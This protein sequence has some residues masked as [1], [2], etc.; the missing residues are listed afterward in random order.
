MRNRTFIVMT[1]EMLA[2]SAISDCDELLKTNPAVPVG[3]RAEQARSAYPGKPFPTNSSTMKALVL[4][5][6]HHRANA[7]LKAATMLRLVCRAGSPLLSEL[8]TLFDFGYYNYAV[9][10]STEN[11][12][13]PFPMSPVFPALSPPFFV[14]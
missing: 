13:Q 5:H 7:G 11:E 2:D 10:D 3:S 12:S 6:G 4:A 8:E 9:P 14:P 1:F